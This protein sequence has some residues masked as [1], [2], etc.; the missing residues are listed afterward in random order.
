MDEVESC[1]V[2]RSVCAGNPFIKQT[3]FDCYKEVRTF[4]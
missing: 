1:Y 3:N 2:S 4:E